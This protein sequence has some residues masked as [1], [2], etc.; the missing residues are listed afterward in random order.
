[1]I[2]FSV[3]RL[4]RLLS[5]LLNR[6]VKKTQRRKTQQRISGAAWKL[7]SIIKGKKRK[8]FYFHF[9]KCLQRRTKRS[10][11][12]DKMIEKTMCARKNEIIFSSLSE[13]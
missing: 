7:I 1:M 5:Y 9:V 11:A 4:E 8:S 2:D 13:Q 10:T 3:L 6:K 12:I